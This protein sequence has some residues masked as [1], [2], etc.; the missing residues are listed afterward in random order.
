M[1]G[2]KITIQIQTNE[3]LGYKL[4]LNEMERREELARLTTGGTSATVASKSQIT[5]L[6]KGKI[7]ES[8]NRRTMASENYHPTCFQRSWLR[9][10]TP[11]PRR[12]MRNKPPS[13]MRSKAMSVTSMETMLSRVLS[14]LGE[15]QACWAG[16]H[17]ERTYGRHKTGSPE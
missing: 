5:P 13:I 12:R 9:P 3:Y 1:R 10:N 15:T 2:V 14:V 11:P 8:V 6:R 7:S 4:E 16:T 17:S